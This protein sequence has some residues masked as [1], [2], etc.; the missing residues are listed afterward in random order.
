[1]VENPRTKTKKKEEKQMKKMVSKVAQKSVLVKPTMA[2]TRAQVGEFLGLSAGSSVC[3]SK[4]GMT[5]RDGKIQGRDIIS[6]LESGSCRK[7]RIG[8]KYASGT[9]TVVAR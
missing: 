8:R 5:V 3:P 6:Y 4:Y 9:V 2:Y 7:A 1:M